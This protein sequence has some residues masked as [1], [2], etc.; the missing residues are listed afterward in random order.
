M[1]N[2]KI[3]LYTGFILIAGAQGLY[4]QQTAS[5][6]MRWKDFIDLNKYMEPFWKADTIYD[7]TVQLIQDKGPAEG[8]L[9]FGAKQVL[10][11]RSANVRTTFEENKDWKYAQG[12][13][14][15]IPG[16]AIPFFKKE[17]L[18]YTIEKKGRSMQGKNKGEFVPFSEDNY[19]RSMQISVTYV[20]L[21]DKKWNGPKP[22]FAQTILPLSVSKLKGKQDFKVVFFGNSIETGANSSGYQNESPFMPSWPELIINNLRKNYNGLISFN[23]Q[24]VGG[25]MAQWGQDKAAEVVVPQKP[26]LVIIGFGMNDGSAKVPPEKYRQNIQSIMDTVLLS[27]PAAEFILIAPMLAN[28]F[29]IQSG[30]QASYKSELDKLAK[31]GVAIADLTGVHRALLQHKSYQDMTGNNVNHPN[32]YL[33]RWYAQFIS[34]LLIPEEK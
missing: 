31:K 32:D 26:D 34:G 2:W 25:M 5:T 28:P 24:S 17:D 23:N 6:E 27:N 4:G 14:I 19:F 9:L 11:V 21:K 10:S 8:S 13:I 33:A 7:E 22:V 16:S 1:N 12:K 18:V 29:A 15:I 30:I 20:P 3:V